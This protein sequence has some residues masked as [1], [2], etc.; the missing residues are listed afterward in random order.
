M[1]K[2]RFEDINMLESVLRK[3]KRLSNNLKQKDDKI[4]SL[5]KKISFMRLM[6]FLYWM[7][8]LLCILTDDYKLKQIEKLMDIVYILSLDVVEYGKKYFDE[9]Y[10]KNNICMFLSIC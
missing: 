9:I 10:E 1:V 7:I 3:N 5:E 8:I 2:V 6:V 4:K